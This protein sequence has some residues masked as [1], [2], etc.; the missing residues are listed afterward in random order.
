MSR[1]FIEAIKNRRSIYGLS[2]D[3]PVTDQEI[4]EIL[5]TALYNLP[6]SFNSQTTRLVLL[7]KDNHKELWEI[8]KSILKSRIS[9]DRF[10]QTEIKINSCFQAGYGTILFYEDMEIVEGFQTSFPSYSD[11]FPVWSEHTSAIHQF[12]IWTMLEDAGLGASLQHYNP[13][14]DEEVAKRWEINPKWK[15][16]AQ[17][18]FGKPI[19]PPAEKTHE[20]LEKRLII[21]Q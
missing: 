1:N 2:D 7:L 5:E 6:S 3:I 9:A 10:E 4:K 8:T 16:I 15:L 12:A 14:I 11:R 19:V 17:M 13:L 18:P 21:P 20:A